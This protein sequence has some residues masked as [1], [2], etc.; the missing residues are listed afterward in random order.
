MRFAVF[1]LLASTASA[2]RLGQEPHHFVKLQQQMNVRKALIKAKDLPELDSE[3][4][5]AAED[6]VKHELTTGDKTITKKEAAKAIGAY[7][8]S[9]G[10]KIS[11]ED[12]KALEAAF[13]AADTNGDGEL[14]KPQNLKIQLIYFFWRFREF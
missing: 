4:E 6:W 9:K 12:W 2:V 8:K 10:V 3:D 7:A 5:K 1:A 11:K 14:E 13:D